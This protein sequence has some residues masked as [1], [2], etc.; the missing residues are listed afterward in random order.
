M[1]V[2][3]FNQNIELSS[4]DICHTCQVKANSSCIL[5]AGYRPIHA[6]HPVTLHLRCFVN[7]FGSGR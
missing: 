3:V 7:Y 6:I 1:R 4:Q 5:T 2:M